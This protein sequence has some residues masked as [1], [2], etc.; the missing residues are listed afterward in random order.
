MAKMKRQTM[1]YKALHR[2]LT[3]EQHKPH[4]YKLCIVVRYYIP[5]LLQF[6]M[7]NFVICQGFFP[8]H[9]LFY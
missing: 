3:I 8:W 4:Y 5:I 1:N 9:I 6:S 2:K 7:I